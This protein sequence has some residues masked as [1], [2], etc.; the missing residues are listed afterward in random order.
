VQRQGFV[1]PIDGHRLRRDETGQTA[2]AED[3]AG[4]SELRLD[5]GD[6][7]VDEAGVAV[8]E[9]GLHRLRR[10][11][12]DDARRLDDLHR[13]QLGRA[14]EE[15][16]GADLDA[17][18][19]DAPQVF[20][21]VADAVERGRGA[22]VDHH[23][24]ALDL[25]VGG[26]RVDD[27]IRSDLARAVVQ[28]RHPGAHRGPDHQGLA[29]ERAPHDLTQWIGEGRDHAGDDAGVDLPVVDVAQHEHLAHEDRVFVGGALPRA[30]AAK[31]L[32]Q[33]ISIEQ[34]EP[35]VGIADVDGEQH[36]AS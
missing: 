36:A 23:H 3:R 28:D 29:G 13:M 6:H 30:L 15:R 20:A 32:N 35:D 24:A 18:R 31:L 5:A 34:T 14:R 21:L 1:D 10:I 22:E 19:N 17:G 26:Y 12:T 25:I 8:D 7:A 9:P 11:A 33:P 27:A 2:G 4:I 16:L